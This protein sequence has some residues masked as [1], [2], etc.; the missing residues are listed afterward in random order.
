MQGK[1]KKRYELRR[2]RKEKGEGEK[3][4]SSKKEYK[5]I[6]ERKKKEERERIIQVGEA[7]TEGKYGN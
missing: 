3:Y 4:R 5:E 1:E 7:K 6:Y 2:W